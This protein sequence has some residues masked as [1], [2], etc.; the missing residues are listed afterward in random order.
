MKETTLGLDQNLPFYRT[1]LY[2]Q[3]SKENEHV[4]PVF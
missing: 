2:Y 1:F 3:V 4:D